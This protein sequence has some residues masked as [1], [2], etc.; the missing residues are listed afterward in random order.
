MLSVDWIA[1][2]FCSLNFLNIKFCSYRDFNRFQKA[3]A[4]TDT[5]QCIGDQSTWFCW[6]WRHYFL[7]QCIF[8]RNA[9]MLLHRWLYLFV[10]IKFRMRIIHL[11]NK[12]IFVHRNT[13]YLLSLL[14]PPSPQR[15]QINIFWIGWRVRQIWTKESRGP[16]LD[17]S[18]TS[19]SY[20]SPDVGLIGSFFPLIF[21][22]SFAYLFIH[23]DII[24][25]NI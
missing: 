2:L 11:W 18:P 19:F 15:I 25:R 24:M 12:V 4:S 21:S 16:N 5:F 22:F 3:I 1:V 20:I 17:L 23:I 14:T 9:Y 8:K 6:L 13:S 7:F 10:G